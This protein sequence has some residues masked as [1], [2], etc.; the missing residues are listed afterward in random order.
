MIKVLCNGPLA[1]I[2]IHTC[3]TYK[4]V[5]SWRSSATQTDEKV[6]NL[7]RRSRKGDNGRAWYKR[8]RMTRKGKVRR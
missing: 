8:G 3:V 5:E 2:K 6:P 4:S 1:R 7:K